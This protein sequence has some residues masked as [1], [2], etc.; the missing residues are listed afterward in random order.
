M[1]VKTP[2]GITQRVDIPEIV[3]QGGGWGP[4]ECSVSIDKIGRLCHKRKEHIYYYNQKV[5]VTPLAMID[6]LIAVAKCGLESV[7]INTFI[8]THTPNLSG[9][10]KCHRIHV[11]RKDDCCPILKIHNTEMESVKFDS[12]LGDIISSDGSNKLNVEN[13]VKKGLGKIAANYDS[14]NLFS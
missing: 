8:V 14:E 10:S 7:A 6:D 2:V 13:R 9:N 4:I 1:A 3:Q 11:G 12:Y 5:E